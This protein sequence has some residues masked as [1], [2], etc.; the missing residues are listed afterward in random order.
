MNEISWNAHEHSRTSDPETSKAAAR[1]MRPHTQA[2]MIQ[3]LDSLR[4]SPQTHSEVALSTGLKEQQVWKRISDLK[5][6]CKVVASGLEKVGPS[7]R[8]Q[9]IWQVV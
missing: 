6:D 1:S 2:I 8:R 9:T 4:M 3:I 5:N 7:G